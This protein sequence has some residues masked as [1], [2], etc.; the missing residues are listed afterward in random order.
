[1]RIATVLLGS[2]GALLIGLAGWMFALGDQPINRPA[3]YTATPTYAAS[4][5]P[6]LATG[7]F[8]GQLAP[9]HQ[10]VPILTYHYIRHHDDPADLLGKRLSV[11]PDTFD[12]HLEALA[13]AGI[14]TITPHQFVAGEFPE[15]SVILSFDD[16]YQDFYLEAFPRLRE[17]SMTAV[18][19]VIYGFLDD[20][21]GQY[22]RRSQV[23]ELA[24]AGVE[25]GSHTVSHPNL[26][27]LDDGR[28]KDQL[29]DSRSGLERL[30]GERVI[31]LAYPAGEVDERVQRVADF[32][33]YR[34][35]VTTQAG[36]ARR[37]DDHL[38]LPRL[39]ISH[40][41]SAETL[42][43]RLQQAFAEPSVHF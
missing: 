36:T 33:G 39:R 4:S 31:A 28:L 11:S 41:E 38:L 35:A 5:S 43:Q 1:M 19:F 24:A 3:F 40:D 14:T 37:S 29:M 9:L 16:G 20:E 15:R 2:F 10:T 23:A 12:A 22:L 17:R 30:T 32:V 27:T 7:L 34:F 26:A 8:S 18:V 13:E 25:I 6:H 42:L 21:S